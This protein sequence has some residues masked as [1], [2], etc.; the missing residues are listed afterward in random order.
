MESI[1]RRRRRSLFVFVEPFCFGDRVVETRGYKD[2]FPALFCIR[3]GAR[4]HDQP[5]SLSRPTESGRLVV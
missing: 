3:G 5:S 4:H 1:R 2:N